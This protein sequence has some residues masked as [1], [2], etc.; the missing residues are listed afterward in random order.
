M[1]LRP[2]RPPSI[3]TQRE[4]VLLSLLTHEECYGLELRSRYQNWTTER[5]PLGALYTTLQRIEDKGFIKSRMGESIAP[6]GGNRRRYFSI[7][8]KGEKALDEFLQ[9]ARRVVPSP[10]R[11]ALS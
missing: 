8:G 2:S 3:R 9:R 5:L 11:G 4:A 7:T 10:R 1:P 6:R